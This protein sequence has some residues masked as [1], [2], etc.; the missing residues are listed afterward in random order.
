LH[1]K[2]KPPVER[3]RVWKPQLAVNDWT[4]PENRR[5]RME[6]FAKEKGFDPLIPENWY[7]VERKDFVK[8][9][10]VLSNISYS[11]YLCICAGKWFIAAF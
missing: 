2:I 3:E 8:E 1:N 6:D 4:K 10:F 11:H 9:V 7:S 5:K